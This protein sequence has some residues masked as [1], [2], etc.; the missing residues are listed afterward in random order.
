MSDGLTLL[1]C[2]DSDTLLAV[3]AVT[4]ATLDYRQK[5]DEQLATLIISKLGEALASD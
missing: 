3:A 5:L 1:E 2:E 4:R